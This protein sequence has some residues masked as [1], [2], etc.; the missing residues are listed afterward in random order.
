[1]TKPTTSAVHDV[2]HDASRLTHRDVRVRRR[3]LHQAHGG[4][5]LDLHHGL[6]AVGEHARLALRA[7][8]PRDVIVAGEASEL[9]G[10]NRQHPPEPRVHRRIGIPNATRARLSAI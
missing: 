9:V 3:L 8:G 10:G 5:I 4:L 1:M 7:V 6:R 2:H